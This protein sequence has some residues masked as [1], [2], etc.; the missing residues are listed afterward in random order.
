MQGGWYEGEWQDG[1]RN[2]MGVRVLRNGTYK[3][4]MESFPRLALFSPVLGWVQSPAYETGEDS[5]QGVL[6]VALFAPVS[7]LQ[8]DIQSL[9]VY[10]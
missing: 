7:A 5:Y 2:G 6:Q 1:E 4:S 9:L 3:V 10:F 8:W